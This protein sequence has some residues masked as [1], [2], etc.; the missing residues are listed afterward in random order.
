MLREHLNFIVLSTIRNYKF[1]TFTFIT[2][3]RIVL[4]HLS[5]MMWSD[6]PTLASIILTQGHFL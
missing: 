4:G 3:G 2:F 1:W 6:M 5:S